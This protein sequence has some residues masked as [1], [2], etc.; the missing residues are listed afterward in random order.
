MKIKTWVDNLTDESSLWLNAV[1]EEE[2]GNFIEASTYYLRNASEC[3]KAGMTVRAALSS[4][5][6]AA[7]LERSG[8]YS[9]AAK[10]YRESGSIYER[11]ANS[12]VGHSIRESLWCLRQAYTCFLSGEDH[13]RAREVHENLLSL[14][15]RIAPFSNRDVGEMTNL[16]TIRPPFERGFVHSQPVNENMKR[17]LEDFLTVQQSQSNNI[18]RI[19]QAENRGSRKRDGDK[20]ETSSLNQL[21]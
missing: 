17:A 7:C 16:E 12:I 11:H 19:R 18:Q 14:E 15:Q 3:I 1:R 5:C 9:Y 8:D 10:L 20:L 13:M 2:A 21:G 4:Y 6:A